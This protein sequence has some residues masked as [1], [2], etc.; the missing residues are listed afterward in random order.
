MQL[1]DDQ[2]ILMNSKYG[3]G[4]ESAWSSV[5]YFKKKRYEMHMK[6]KWGF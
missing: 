6:Q 3:I 1:S 4:F 5:P 2:M